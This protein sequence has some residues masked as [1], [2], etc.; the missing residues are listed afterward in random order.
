MKT[1][2]EVYEN[3]KEQEIKEGDHLFCKICGRE[4]T[5]TKEGKG[6]L[7]CCDQPMEKKDLVI[8]A[9]FKNM[10]KGWNRKSVKKWANTL[11]KNESE[12][13]ATKKGFFQKCV[14][15]M[16][17]KVENPEGYCASVKDV[18]YNSTGW[19]GKGKSPQQVKKDIRKEKF[20]VK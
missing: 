8:E 14:T 18:A 2:L 17:G 13:A 7:V 4:C 19:R 20:K 9:G 11:V 1:L 6:P 16:K 12:N 5:I 15:K 10:P 3:I